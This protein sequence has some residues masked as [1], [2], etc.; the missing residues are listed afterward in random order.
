MNK[1]LQWLRT[2]REWLLWPVRREPFFFLTLIALFGFGQIFN[3]GYNFYISNDLALW[4]SIKSVAVVTF[5]SYLLT[6][7]ASSSRYVKVT[8]Y[9]LALLL[10]FVAL[11]VRNNFM[12]DINPVMLQVV[13]ETDSGEASDFIRTYALSPGTVKCYLYIGICIVVIIA[14]ERWL[15]R[16]MK[17][18]NRSWE[19]WLLA[20]LLVL[21]MPYGAVQV[22]TQ[23]MFYCP[24]VI[25]NE[26]YEYQKQ[27]PTDVLSNMNYAVL[28]VKRVQA[29]VNREFEVATQAMRLPSECAEPDTLHVCVVIGESYIKRH[30]GVYGYEL[31]TTP[32]LQ[33][34]LEAGNLFLFDDVISTY[35]STT[36][37]MKD[38]LSTNHLARGENW[39]D[40]PFFPLLFKKAGYF[41][42]YWDNQWDKKANIFDFSLGSIVHNRKML[43]LCYD[44]ENSKRYQ[45]DMDLL[46]SYYKEAHEAAMNHRL[47]LEMFHLMGQ[48]MYAGSRFPHTAEWERFGVSDIKRSESWMTDKKRGEIVNYDNATY[49]N[50]AV[51]GRLIDS[52]RHTTAVLVYFSDHGEEVYDWRDFTGRDYREKMPP[53]AMKLQFGV[54]FMVWCSPQFQRRYPEV[55]ERLRDSRERSW[56]IDDVPHL[57]FDLGRVKSKYYVGEFD[58]ISPNYKPSKRIV[59]DGIDYDEVINKGA[60]RP[61]PEINQF[62]I[63]R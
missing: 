52:L 4:K 20:L 41:V 21:T 59:Q 40:Y 27:G 49:Y 46:D 5:V 12:S 34:E 16:F 1:V 25:D 32:R 18:L 14:G 57:L 8:L 56:I 3:V 48:H 33:V 43:P 26:I 24:S 39:Y 23:A 13:M 44:M 6:W 58:L 9:A 61:R 28:A 38:I 31:P 7:L 54:P 30:A 62:E 50:D 36:K 60:T 55:V 17:W 11:F 2:S 15:P 47:S 19:R 45:Y 37:S 22:V 51:M 10:K 53:E 63:N 35:I 42:T 29:T